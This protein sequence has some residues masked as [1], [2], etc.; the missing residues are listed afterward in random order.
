MTKE[1]WDVINEMN[2]R[3]KKLR[4]GEV[5]ICDACGE[6]VLKPIGDAKSTH[7]FVCESCGV[8]INID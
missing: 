5:V 2:D 1:Q 4:S 7:C 8:R 3:M 6:G